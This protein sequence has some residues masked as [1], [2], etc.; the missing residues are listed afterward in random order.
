MKLLIIF[1]FGLLLS[2]CSTRPILEITSHPEGAYVTE[3]V[4][5][6]NLGVTPLRISLNLDEKTKGS[7]GCYRMYGIQAFWV[8][9]AKAESSHPIRICG[10]NSGVYNF[11]FKRLPDAPGVAK[12]IAYANQRLQAKAAEEQIKAAQDAAWWAAFSAGYSQSRATK[13]TFNCTHFGDF[14]SCR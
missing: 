5:N 8:S 2:G 6:K 3:A 10:P 13:S 14:T 11:N 7:D 9:G 4:T 1:I 12:D